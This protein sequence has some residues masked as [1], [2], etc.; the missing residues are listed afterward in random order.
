MRTEFS[1]PSDK[2]NL[3]AWFLIII[4]TAIA[5][6]ATDLQT[7][8]NSRFEIGDYAANS[9][10][11]QDAKSLKLLIG[12]YSRVGFNHPGPAIL[13]VLAA[14]E[15]IFYD[16]LHIVASPIA[17]QLI[18]AEIFRACWL[19]SIVSLLVRITGTLT[20][21]FLA[22]AVFVF[23]A[24][25]LY[26][27]L[28]KGLWF[29]LLYFFPFSTFLLAA[30]RLGSGRIDSWLALAISSGFLINGHASFI[31]IVLIIYFSTFLLNYF[32]SRKNEEIELLLS[33]RFL[34]NNK[35]VVFFFCSTLLVFFLPLLCETFLNYPG[36]ISDYI[37]F[38]G[39][40]KKN[41][42]ADAALYTSYYWGGLLAMLTGFSLSIFAT[43]IVLQFK[44]EN[45][46]W[47]IYMAIFLFAAGTLN[48]IIKPASVL[49]NQFND[50]TILKLYQSLNNIKHQGRLILDINA[51]DDMPRVA[52][53][54]AGILNYT[55]RQHNN[56][57]CINMN[58]NI[59]FTRE[60]K[61]QLDEA[62]N[63]TH[64]L[65]QPSYENTIHYKEKI[66]DEGGISIYTISQ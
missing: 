48:N 66:I 20:R 28:F 16:V 22:S 12:N 1:P 49:N 9:L 42:I 29:P 44:L 64:L 37:R 2:L 33:L 40:H 59:A 10:L 18:A 47:L 53:I 8:C 54:T 24:S 58:W 30:S 63:G 14:G 62:K 52:A 27:D 5:L 19:S 65:M 3:M 35:T 56:F 11:I 60:S 45:N 32:Q 50:P 17:G 51:K 13:Y 15:Y 57:I 21:G 31:A 55:K 36:P 41:G 6:I 39:A 7:I 26:Y 4:V 25:T 61:C 46:P 38:S 23:A 43:W 34:K